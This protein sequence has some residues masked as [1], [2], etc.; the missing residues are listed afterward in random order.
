MARFVGLLNFKLL[1]NI[2]ILDIDYPSPSNRRE[3]QIYNSSRRERKGVSTICCLFGVSVCLYLYVAD[4][5]YG[6]L[7]SE[8]QKKKTKKKNKKN[9]KKEKKSRRYTNEMKWRK[10]KEKMKKKS[11][12]IHF[13]GLPVFN[14]TILFSHYL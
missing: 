2:E 1:R 10:N 12:E 7:Y 6:W 5:D 4:E 9:K 11:G 14:S 3:I 8:E 13:I